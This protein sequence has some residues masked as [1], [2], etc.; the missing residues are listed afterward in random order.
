[1]IK[2]SQSVEF[3][4]D[5]KDDYLKWICGFANAKGGIMY[6]GID[7]LGKVTGVSN[8][9]KLLEDLPNKIRD[10][11]GIM[12]DVNLL[13]ENGKNY[14]EIIIETYNNPVSYKGHFY[15]RS[16]TTNQELKGP[17]LEKLLLKKMGKKWDGIAAPSFKL[18]DLSTEAFDIFRKKAAK[19]KRVPHEILNDTNENILRSL[20]MYSGKLFSRAAII[21]FGKNP[22]KLISGAFVK[23]GFFRTDTDL[24]FHDEIHGNLFAQVEKTL[25]LLL[26]KYIKA[27]IA[28]EKHTRVETYEYPEDALREALLNAL[29]HK[30]YSSS[31]PIQ[32]S[33][34]FDW[35]FIWNPGNLPEGWTIE[36]LKQKHLSDPANPDI[37]KAFFNAGYIE[38]WGRGTLNI[39]KYCKDARL[40]EPVFYDR[41][42]G[43]GVIIM[44][45]G[46]SPMGK[47]YYNDSE[48]A[49]EK[50]SE[51]T[52][53]KIIG[54]IEKRREI[55][56]QEL[57][58]I[59]NVS[60]RSIERNL[61][62]LKEKG[63]LKRIGPDK[64]G[65]WE[66]IK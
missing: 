7:D 41:L 14:L 18:E 53:E 57:C 11:L 4:S 33:V 58:Q 54:L 49:S 3:K 52:S 32:I 9:K 1:M 61:K 42:G 34:Y 37:A 16:G 31:N 55:T 35:I 30:D 51:K 60:K 44:K 38:S 66:I 21:S 17:A 62:S 6:I 27:N 43:L 39:I 59:I 8:S 45:P 19:S 23:I 22:E 50:T 2:E 28:Y 26:T 47:T 36:D 46:A 13:T 65:Y 64:G 24:L 63:I 12:V 5:W 10:I 25:D 29:I 15:Y 40:P 20:G 48:K 56:I